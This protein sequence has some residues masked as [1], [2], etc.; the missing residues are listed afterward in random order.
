M[1]CNGAPPRSQKAASRPMCAASLQALSA[2]L[3]ALGPCIAVSPG[4]CWEQ[5]EQTPPHHTLRLQRRRGPG[6]TATSAV[7]FAHP[8]AYKTRAWCLDLTR[9]WI[10]SPTPRP[11]STSKCSSTAA[12]LLHYVWRWSI[13]TVADISYRVCHF[14]YIDF[15]RAEQ[16]TCMYSKKHTQKYM[17][18]AKAL[19]YQYN[20]GLVGC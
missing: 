7:F 8:L 15:L 14:L 13:R 5:E 9:Q 19:R 2:Q 6:L 1:G 3:G 17:N 16:T 11:T 18:Y 20:R 12:F 4:Q 10:V